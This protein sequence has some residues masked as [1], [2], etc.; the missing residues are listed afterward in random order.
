VTF[1]GNISSG[2]GSVVTKAFTYTAT[3]TGN[4]VLVYISC[5]DNAG[6]PS[7]V[8]LTATGWSF[9]QVGTIIGS[10]TAGF[11]A[12]FKAYAPNTT[13]ATLTQTWTATNC[14]A[15]GAT[16]IN[17][18]VDE[19]ARAWTLTNF[20]DASNSVDGYVGDELRRLWQL[21]T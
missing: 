9:T 14:G 12:L 19:W 16:F 20:V 10:T 7:A 2:C 21:R 4:G 18:L 11:G 3:G 17:D 8:S 13:A 5:A 1:G 6:T 15:A